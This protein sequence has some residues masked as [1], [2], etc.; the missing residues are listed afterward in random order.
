MKLDFH[1]HTNFSPDGLSPPQAIV[2]AAID[3]GLNCICITDHNET[4]GAVE[5]MKYAFDKN[6]LIIPG[7][8]VSTQQ[9]DILGIHVKKII[10]RG[11]TAKET[12]KEI[13]KQGGLAIIAH[14]FNWP[15]GHFRGGLEEFFMA[16]AIECFN[17]NLFRFSNTRAQKFSKSHNLAFTSSSDAHKAK[18][19]GRGYLEIPGDNLTEKE[20]LEAI[21][22][23]NGKIFGK[24][25]TMLELMENA[26]KADLT[27]LLKYY[28]DKPKRRRV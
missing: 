3:K 22:N 25:L 10:P 23:R 1:V 7:I 6:I 8:E 11:L 16:D 26:M 5:V 17:A 18:F 14:P 4:K 21:K 27:K 2:D 15:T 12:I 28:E 19:V 9:G 20:I 13:Q 24:V